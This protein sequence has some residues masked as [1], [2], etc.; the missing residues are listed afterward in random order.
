MKMSVSITTGTRKNG[1]RPCNNKGCK[2]CQHILTTDMF[3][4]SITGKSYKVHTSATCKTKGVVYLI[5]CRKCRKQY[6][7]STKN[8]L[9]IRL[10]GHTSD[11]RR[12]KMQKPVAY[13]FNKRGHSMKD[14]AIM[15]I[16]KIPAGDV[17]TRRGRE[18]HERR[19]IGT[20]CTL[21]PGGM[22]L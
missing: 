9:H 5:E 6:V 2:T 18:T 8:G 15:V 20:L 14:V 22:N 10:N 1:N 4:S 7:G 3:R 21:H 17:Q 13:H 16:E 12:K 11:I 19:W